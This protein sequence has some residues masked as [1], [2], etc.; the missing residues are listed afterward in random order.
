VTSLADGRSENFRKHWFGTH[1]FNPPRYMKLLEIIPTPDTDPRALADF[2]EFAE[3]ILGKGIVRAKDTPNFIANRIGL[4]GALKTI[5]L[6]QQHGFTFEEVDRLTG[7]LIG[8]P[9]TATFRTIDMV[10]IDVFVH[11]ADNIYTNALNDPHREI[12]RIPEFM[13]SMLNRKI[14]GAKTGRGFYKKEGDQI[15]TLDVQTM[16]YRPQRKPSL[17]ALE[18][19]SGI[20]SLPER[21]KA[22]FKTRD[23]AAAFVS[24]LLTS[25]S[26]YAA[27]RIPEISDDPEAV[28]SAMRWGFA[29][30]MGPFELTKVL[31]GDSVPPVS[32]LKKQ[33]VIRENAGAGLRDLGDGV[34]CLEFHSKMNTIGNDIISLLFSSLDEVNA[35]FDGLVIGNDGQNFSAGANLMLLMMEAVEGN[36]DEIDYM[37]RTFQRA[38]QAIRYNAKPVVT[39]PF[40]LALGGGCEI[41]MAGSR[42]QASA[43]TYMGLVEVGAGLIPAGGGTT[44]MLRRASIGG[45]R[46]VREIF[47]NIGFAKV[48]TSAEDARRLL[49][50]RPEDGVTMNPDRVIHDA[51]AVVRALAA[52]G[53]RPPAPA[54]LPVFG[55]PL[56]AEL[57][58]GVHLMRQ[59]GHITDYEAHI[60]RKLAHVLCGGDVTRQSTAP[61]QYFLDLEREAFKSLCG[62]QKTLARMEHLLKKGK[63]LRN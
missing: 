40:A 42:A 62:E 14:L 48:S 12:F 46:R 38:T 37:V 41:A 55:T 21:L 11:V 7:P 9:K 15:L 47:E 43:E 58:L 49:Y 60:A 44:E 25:I 6:M 54:D 13:R 31:K 34:A 20:E 52:T 19:V 32:F 29:W 4:F 10:G 30:E 5:Q 35:N 45:V 36:W 18:M 33:A 61:E 63:V 17:P 28:D 59:A 39:A 22:L 50:L 3:I 24:D 26:D 56:A 53:Y 27:A 51:K 1:F 8:R 57:N 16:D 2:E 23:P